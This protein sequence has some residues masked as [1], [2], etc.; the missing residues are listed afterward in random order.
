MINTKEMTNAS[1]NGNRSPVSIVG[2]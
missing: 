1:A 2:W